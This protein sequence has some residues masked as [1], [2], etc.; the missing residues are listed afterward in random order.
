M[1]LYKV[2]IQDYFSIFSNEHLDTS[3]L[4]PTIRTVAK[5][6][7]GAFLLSNILF[8]IRLFADKKS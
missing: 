7:N 2:L 6:G 4:K 3:S 8:A 1:L 5:V